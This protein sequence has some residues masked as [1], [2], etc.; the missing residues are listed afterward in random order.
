MRIYKSIEPMKNGENHFF[1][2]T[3]ADQVIKNDGSR[4][5]TDRGVNADLLNGKTA[6]HYATKSDCD[7][8]LSQS[9]Y[10][11]THTPGKL[12]GIGVNGKFKATITETVST[13]LIND[14]SYLVKQGEETEIELIKG[15]WYIFIL[16][17]TTINFNT[18][19][20]NLNFKIIGSTTQPASP[21]E[22]TIWVSTDTVIG[23]HQFSLSTPTTRSNGDT[24]QIGDIWIRCTSYSE[25]E[26]NIS[27][28]IKIPLQ[29]AWIWDGT[30]WIDVEAKIYQNNTWKDLY[31]LEHENSWYFWRTSTIN[32]QPKPADF[33][34]KTI[35]AEGIYADT[36]TS[37]SMN[38]ADSYS[39]IATT[40]LFFD[41]D[42]T[43]SITFTT[44]DAGTVTLN[45]T[46][47]G[48]LASCAATAVSC[49]FKKGWN[50]LEVC[51][52][53]GSGGDG[54]VTSPKISTLE[55]VKK[56]YAN[57]NRKV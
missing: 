51:Y 48:N 41:A 14:K 45:D 13:I 26:L 42:E 16:D 47:I 23:K 27:K 21:K 19:G 52:T 12:A 28:N 6:D 30:E 31:F 1:P 32:S 8:A 25:I 56:M 20:A 22:N 24:L 53:E 49:P 40:Y 54:W 46:H 43:I 17:D 2:L 33:I 57:I 3:T 38:M 50:K 29:D 11:Y 18:G 9:I 44:D 55:S 10:Q 7:T 5:S 39:G 34:G 15:C 37:I 4:L 35:V 36:S